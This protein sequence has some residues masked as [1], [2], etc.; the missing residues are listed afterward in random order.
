MKNQSYLVLLGL[1]FFSALQVSAQNETRKTVDGKTYIVHKVANGETLY[2]ISKKYS[3]SVKD[4]QTA[5]DLSGGLKAGQ[6]I[7]VPTQSNDKLESN[8]VSYHTV[9]SGETLS[10][11][12]R[13]YNTT[14]E[15]LKTLNSLSSASIQVGQSLKVPS[16]GATSNVPVVEEVK[17]A[18]VEVK[19][20]AKP[21]ENKPV[22]VVKK[23]AGPRNDKGSASDSGKKAENADGGM[24]R[25]AEVL[26]ETAT[27]KEEV[28]MALVKTDEMDQTRTF[29]MH[30]SLPKGS[31]IVVINEKTG[32]MAYCRV[33]D[34][35]K[36]ADLNGASVA[37]TK[38]VADKIGLKDSKGSV[39]I[40]YA[41]P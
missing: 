34:N 10:G 9:A 8:E 25:T 24:P 29:V 28:G 35:I 3:I 16:G 17:P 31:I 21:V 37:I 7:L 5:N 27:E 6:T 36:P 19:E 11:I 38:T 15:E 14:V 41:A 32:K 33:V 18:V 30:P 40:K 39:K 1:V 13:K 26:A 12:A 22:A 2:G 20:E 23:P 4:I